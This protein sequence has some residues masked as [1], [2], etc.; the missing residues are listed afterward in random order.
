MPLIQ[1]IVF[2]RTSRRHQASNDARKPT[3]TVISPILPS[4]NQVTEDISKTCLGQVS[5][6][7]KRKR[8]KLCRL[9]KEY[10]DRPEAWFAVGCYYLCT[11]Q[12][13]LARRYFYKAT[14]V[15]HSFAPAWIGFG[16][17]FALQ[18]ESDQVQPWQNYKNSRSAVHIA[19]TTRFL[20]K[21]L[22]LNKQY[23][24]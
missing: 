15:G 23:C 7:E 20:C 6:L 18:D 22:Q 5:R 16:H 19:W 17:A 21:G 13:E 24:Q 12:L 1:T 2:L 8:R 3:I 11:R 14:T 4:R 10:P 9:V